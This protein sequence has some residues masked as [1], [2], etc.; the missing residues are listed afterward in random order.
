MEPLRGSQGPLSPEGTVQGEGRPA[1]PFS[2]DSDKKRA[3]SPAIS[4]APAPLLK[5]VL[6]LQGHPRQEAA[7]TLGAS[8]TNLC[9]P[10]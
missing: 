10:I 7:G 8:G 1:G 6:V 4:R 5:A 3:R 2:R 9:T